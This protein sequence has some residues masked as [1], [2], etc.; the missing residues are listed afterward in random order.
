MT[1]TIHSKN[2]LNR[3]L[4]CQE[5]DYDLRE[6]NFHII[7]CALMRFMSWFSLCYRA[8]LINLNG[9]N[10]HLFYHEAVFRC[11][12]LL[13][14]LIFKFSQ[15]LRVSSLLERTQVLFGSKSAIWAVSSFIDALPE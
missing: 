15:V 5:K 2:L 11:W 1:G 9:L 3:A 7:M 6:P 4:L 8:K 10:S 13:D 12:K 14:S